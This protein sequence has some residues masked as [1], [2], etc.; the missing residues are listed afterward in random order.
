MRLLIVLIT[1]NRKAYTKKTLSNLFATIDTPYY[2]VAV[3]NASTDD[4]KDYLTSLKGRNKLDMLI[5]NEGNYYPG[6]AC[7]IGWSKGLEAYPQAT[8]LM[9]LDNDMAF[10]KGWDAYAAEYFDTIDRL[11]Q[12]GLDYDGG[13]DKPPQ[14]YNGM[15]LVEFPGCVGGPSIIRR[16]IFD[17]GIRY[18][19]TP[20]KD[21][22]TPLQEDSKFSR[23]VKQQ[24]W[25][26]GHMDKR[27]SYT[28]AVP[29][30]WGD[31][32][33]YYRETMT[34]RGYTDRLKK[35]GL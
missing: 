24:G 26:V 25:L 27:L 16:E 32:P 29:E 13:E 14:F 11:G 18:D 10:E 12:L 21:S 33:Q 34:D 7:N 28:F 30:N 2:L 9:R 4:T 15:G 35:A 22:G 23:E 8:H 17:D 6:K 5:L 3:D 20:W 19:E 31:Y 1:Y